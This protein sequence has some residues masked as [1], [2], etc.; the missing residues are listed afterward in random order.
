MS[1]E[2][3]D[4]GHSAGLDARWRRVAVPEEAFVRARILEVSDETHYRLATEHGLE[5]W[6]QAPEFSEFEVGKETRIFLT[7][8]SEEFRLIPSLPGTS[9]I[10]IKRASLSVRDSGRHYKYLARIGGLYDWF[11]DRGYRTNSA[12]LNMIVLLDVGFPVA[13]LMRI[14]ADS[15]VKAYFGFDDY[16]D[17][18]GNFTI[19]P[20]TP[21]VDSMYTLKAAPWSMRAVE[22][23]YAETGNGLSKQRIPS[24]SERREVRKTCR[25]SKPRNDY[26]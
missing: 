3:I 18:V 9:G 7:M 19:T 15:G 10:G 17:G 11:V 14:D 16:V 22:V 23:C 4:L 5:I 6:A 8:H 24:K 2:R 12:A 26:V 25:D 20:S 13:T 1:E 21:S